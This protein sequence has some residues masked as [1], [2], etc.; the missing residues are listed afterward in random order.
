M[1]LREIWHELFRQQTTRIRDDDK[2][3]TSFV[4]F[5][6]VLEHRLNHSTVSATF[7][8]DFSILIRQSGIIS[9]MFTTSLSH[10]LSSEPRPNTHAT[11]TTLRMVKIMLS[12]HSFLEHFVLTVSSTSTSH[13]LVNYFFYTTGFTTT[14]ERTWSAA[15]V[16]K[17]GE[18]KRFGLGKG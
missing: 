8:Y 5:S 12:R 16:R 2:H 10:Q 15:K 4:V 18:W 6:F 1:Q 9:F 17:T 11:I 13:R 7:S 3:D 14:S